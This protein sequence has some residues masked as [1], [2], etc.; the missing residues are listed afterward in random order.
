MLGNLSQHRFIRLGLLV[1]IGVTSIINMFFLHL[2][3]TFIIASNVIVSALLLFT[4]YDTVGLYNR[5][6]TPPFE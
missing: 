6:K 1:F 2:G 3:W 4:L 5:W